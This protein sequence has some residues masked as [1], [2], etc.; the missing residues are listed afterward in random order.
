MP[1]PEPKPEPM[2]QSSDAS[3]FPQNEVPTTPGT[4]T[5]KR[6]AERLAAMEHKLDVALEEMHR[7]GKAR[8]SAE[9]WFR[10]VV[11]PLVIA[12]THVLTRLWVGK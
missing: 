8:A 10:Y 1:E 5:G 3:S 12:L 11:V 9:R 7:R 4:Q 2:P 6:A